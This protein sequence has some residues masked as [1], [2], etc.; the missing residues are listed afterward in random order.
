MV[1]WGLRIFSFNVKVRGSNPHTC[2]LV[3]QLNQLR[4][5]AKLAYIPR[6]AL[7]L[8]SLHIDLVFSFYTMCL[9]ATC[10]HGMD[11]KHIYFIINELYPM[12]IIYGSHQALMTSIIL[13]SQKSQ[14]QIL[15][16]LTHIS[17]QIKC[18]SHGFKE[19]IKYLKF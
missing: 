9:H 18:F 2:N 8:H 4:L 10:L 3:N 5:I 17:N 7:S 15:L 12:A 1:K 14:S 13:Q 11:G 6:Y 19:D 16:Q